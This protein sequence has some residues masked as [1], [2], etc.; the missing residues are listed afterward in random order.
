M[1]LAMVTSFLFLGTFANCEK[2]LIALSCLSV[3]TDQ[4]GS[5]WNYFYEIQYSSIFRKYVEKISVIK[6]LQE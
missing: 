1:V 3:R 4:L 6:V 5:H 2:R